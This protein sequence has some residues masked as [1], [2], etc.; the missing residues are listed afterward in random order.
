MGLFKFFEQ[1]ELLQDKQRALDQDPKRIGAIADLNTRVRRLKRLLATA[2]VLLL[3]TITLY[4]LPSPSNESLKNEDSIIKDSTRVV[5]HSNVD[6]RPEDVVHKPPNQQVVPT[7]QKIIAADT[8]WNRYI[9]A[10]APRPK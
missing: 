5:P 1:Q 2:V 10:D 9:P 4:I 3:G 7:N 6:N 8:S